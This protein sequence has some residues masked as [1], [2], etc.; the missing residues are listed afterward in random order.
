VNWP[1]PRPG[2]VIRFSYL[3]KREADAGREEG[4]KDR[5]CAILLT[6]K[7]KPDHTRVIVVPVS[8]SSP[9]SPDE[10]VEIP[11]ETEKRLG[12]DSAPAWIVISEANDFVWPGPD[13]RILPGAQPASV[14][15]GFLPPGLF[16]VVRE[17]FL[18]RARAGKARLVPRS[19]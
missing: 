2:L 17:R 1:E 6:V 12:L 10:G 5:P 7:K 16:R 14:A 11:L 4:V 15:Y 9:Q 8:H 3:W 13:L 19:E 18:T